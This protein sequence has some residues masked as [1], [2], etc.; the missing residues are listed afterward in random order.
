M[1]RKRLNFL[2]LSIAMAMSASNGENLYSSP[3]VSPNYNPE[4]KPAT[5]KKLQTFTIKG[6]SIEAYSRK[7]ALKRYNHRAKTK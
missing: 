2:A 1:N 5:P 3:G 6:V 7:D 4:V